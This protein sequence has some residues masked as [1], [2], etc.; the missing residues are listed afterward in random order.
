MNCALIS[1]VVRTNRLRH[2]QPSRYGI[3][4][5]GRDAMALRLWADFGFALILIGVGYQIVSRNVD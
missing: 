5:A 1:P 3:A 2:Y 4:A